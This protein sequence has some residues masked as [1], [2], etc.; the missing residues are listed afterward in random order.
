MDWSDRVVQALAEHRSWSYHGDAP[1]AAEP[2]ALSA[3]A[4]LGHQQPDAARAPLDWLAS[5]QSADGSIGVTE[6]QKAPHW[7][8][9]QAVLAWWHA[10]QT[11]DFADQYQTAIRRGVGWIL[12]AAGT[13]L[14]PTPEL[15]HD[16][17]LIGWPW[18]EGTHSWMEP[19]SW[20][21]LALRTAGYAT[22]ARTREGIRLLV[23]RLLPD[24]G[25]NYGNTYV[26][27]QM[28][29]PHVQP[30]GICLLAL[31]GE[32]IGDRRIPASIDYLLR[33]LSDKTTTI[34]L[35]CGLLGLTAQGHAPKAAD[36][37]LAAAARRTLDRD[38]GAY[39]LALLALAA[40]G[41]RNPLVAAHSRSTES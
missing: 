25:A 27:R 35:C 40:L 20:S 39:K 2:A 38:A 37:F 13:A 41:D 8:T 36:A 28:L 12:Q 6:S 31:A 23:D 14:Q 15:G 30:T 22:H 17:R 11:P 3:L 16:P 26:L 7:P 29:R 4:L 21:V 1:R 10:R 33:E 5:I 18:V 34:S 24:G 19:S 32:P 9:T